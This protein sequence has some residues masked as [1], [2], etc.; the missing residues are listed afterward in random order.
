MQ[1]IAKKYDVDVI[2]KGFQAKHQY[3]YGSPVHIQ[4][5]ASLAIQREIFIYV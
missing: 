5:I 2:Y 3:I 1:T 4:R